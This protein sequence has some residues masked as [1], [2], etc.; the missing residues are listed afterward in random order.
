MD[1]YSVIK[2]ANF[3]LYQFVLT[4]RHL[5]YIWFVDIPSMDK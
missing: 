2:Y 4:M 3:I 1:I 5:R